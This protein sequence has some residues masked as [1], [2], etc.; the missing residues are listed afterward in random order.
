MGQ[1]QVHRRRAAGAHLETSGQGAGK[2]VPA[3]DLKRRLGRAVLPHTPGAP[4]GL[5]VD[6]VVTVRQVEEGDARGP[7]GSP[8]PPPPPVVAFLKH[9]VEG[10]VQHPEVSFTTHTALL[11]GHLEE[12][13][14]EREIVT[15]AVLPAPF[16]VFIIY[17][18]R[19]D[20]VVYSTQ[21][22]S[23]VLAV[24]NGHCDESHVRVWRPLFFS[25]V[26]VGRLGA[27]IQ[28]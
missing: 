15:N 4:V 13:V 23:L 18:F 16:V 27:D 24:L 9:V 12:A 22:Q 7:V 19:L 2:W 11:N 6:R 3:D 25:F 26:T 28:D 1:G 14:V 20:V 21:G 5:Q 8:H 10:G 17:K